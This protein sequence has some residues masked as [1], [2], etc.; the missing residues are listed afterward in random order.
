M[1]LSEELMK[2]GRESA[3]KARK[4]Y[5]EW[6]SF[7]GSRLFAMPDMPGA[8]DMPKMPVT[9]GMPDMPNMPNLPTMAKR[10]KIDIT[11]I[12]TLQDTWW[13]LYMCCIGAGCGRWEDPICGI[14]SQCCCPFVSCS[15]GDLITP[16]EGIMDN[17]CV[18]CGITT[19]HTAMPPIGGAPCAA[20]CGIRCCKCAESPPIFVE[21]ALFDYKFLMM[22]TCW[23]AYCCCF[24]C[25]LNL[26]CDGRP[27]CG[28]GCKLCCIRCQ[29][30]CG[31]PF[32]EEWSC[33]FMIVTCATLWGHWSCPPK[34]QSGPI[35]AVL[36]CRC[37]GTRKEK[38]ANE[39]NADSV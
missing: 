37:K 9:P 20:C 39:A 22:H 16:Q 34:F 11:E 15:T 3:G 27:A 5:Q 7:A 10:E 1:D 4:E 33:C 28:N 26:P 32:N 8:P 17:V 29:E 31:C 30:S 14:E 21:D 36:G 24:G 19:C 12:G 2:K 25:G 35:C 6:V 13:C 18:C 23:C 38:E